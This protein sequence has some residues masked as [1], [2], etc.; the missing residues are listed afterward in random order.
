VIEIMSFRLRPDADENRFLEADARLQT[1]FAYRQ[2][3][4]RRRTTARGDAGGW[5]VIELWRS[6]ADADACAARWD[7]DPVAQKFMTF[8]DRTSVSTTRYDELDSIPG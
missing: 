6:H 3:G 1:E 8:V 2:P 7:H 5:A 4:L